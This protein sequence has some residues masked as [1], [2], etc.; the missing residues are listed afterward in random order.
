M[1]IIL[2]QPVSRGGQCTVQRDFLLHE[3]KVQEGRTVR[4]LPRSKKNREQ[5]QAVTLNYRPTAASKEVEQISVIPLCNSG[6]RRNERFPI[7]SI[8]LS[9]GRAVSRG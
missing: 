9:R 7:G 6:L 4:F 2:L 3:W 1:T 8:C 5:S